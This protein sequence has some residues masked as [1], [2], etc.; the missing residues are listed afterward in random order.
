V[1]LQATVNLEPLRSLLAGGAAPALVIR[2]LA[3]PPDGRRLAREVEVRL[4][5][6]PDEGVLRYETTLVVPAG[7]G[8]YAV[9]VREEA[10][11]AFGAAGPVAAIAASAGVGEAEHEAG[12][13]G[14]AARA[15]AVGGFAET[16][17]VRLG[18][19]RFLMPVDA[20]AGASA[21]SVHWNGV[22][23][24]LTRLAGG[25]G[26]PLELGIAIDVSE[27]VAEEG[28]A[29]ARAAA[30]AA[31]RLLRAGDRVFRVDFGA[32][33]RLVGASTGSAG[34][35]FA[36]A[37][38]GTPEATA[39]F[40]GLSFALERFGGRHDRMALVVFTD[41]CETAGRT[42]W[43][44]VARAAR[45]RAVP[46]FVV[47]ADGSLCTKAIRYRDKGVLEEAGVV[48]PG[49]VIGSADEMRLAQSSRWA[50]GE[51]AKASG[52]ALFRLAQA[53]GA[54]GVW[55]EVETALGRLFVALFEPSSPELDPRQV[56]VRLGGDRLLRPSS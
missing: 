55:G 23:Q 17:D 16:A 6:L 32:A 29:F 34:A 36:A 9:E 20:T 50:L 46:V 4:P 19:A 40:D 30:A 25:P 39:I 27:S 43:Q 18:E 38:A 49:W 54:G 48:S 33:P 52:G 1:T 28:A 5:R 45:L 37:P 26:S 31:A 8:A 12:D 53:D 42:Q 51:I 11:G 15:D 35:L 56:E 2:I 21:V 14:G 41:G 24:R 13:G 47:V 3:T 10:A 7:T 44:D 22:E